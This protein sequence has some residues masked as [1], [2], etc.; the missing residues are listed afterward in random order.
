MAVPR[1]LFRCASDQS[2]GLNSP[3]LFAPASLSDHD[4]AQPSS[5]G[6]NGLTGI[7]KSFGE[8]LYQSLLWKKDQAQCPFIFFTSSPLFAVQLSAWRSARKVDKSG[9]VTDPDTNVII[10]TIDTRTAK[11]FEGHAVVFQSVP[12][13]ISAYGLEI[14]NR[15]DGEVRGY[16]DHWIATTTVVPGEVSHYARFSDLVN[17]GLYDLYPE[18]QAANDRRDPRPQLTT[19]DLRKYNFGSDVA[20]RILLREERVPAARLALCFDHSANGAAQGGKAMGNV[21]AFVLSL[22]HRN[23]RDKALEYWLD[24]HTEESAGVLTG[25]EDEVEVR[26]P[27]GLPDAIEFETLRQH[28]SSK[29]F[30][31]AGLSYGLAIDPNSVE[32]QKTAWSQWWR[33]NKS[34][35]RS[36]H[37]G[38]EEGRAFE[39]RM[40]RHGQGRVHQRRGKDASAVNFRPGGP[41]R[42]Q[43]A[44]DPTH[45]RAM[46][47]SRRGGVH[48]QRERHVQQKKVKKRK[49][50]DRVSDARRY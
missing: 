22:Q 8:Q 45:G 43:S 32:Q 10:S 1:F 24:D 5:R 18:I 17:N 31:V 40:H 35:W 42:Q 46:L 20:H 7:H 28:F 44:L 30:C 9:S 39:D 34:E 21:L 23:T 49:D 4:I 29:E 47:E 12:R 2:N 48:A 15:G 16:E 33:Q 27:R 38:R 14:R 41:G 50:R 26:L 25:D 11:T 37:G 19:G 3:T 36:R 13:L 6:N